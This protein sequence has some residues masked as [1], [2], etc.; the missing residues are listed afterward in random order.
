MVGGERSSERLARERELRPDL[1]DAASLS[2][3]PLPFPL[4]LPLGREMELRGLSD[5]E[6]GM[7]DLQLSVKH[8]YHHTIGEIR[9]T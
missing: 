1:T 3:S 8:T 4:L 7:R 9:P 6:P 2:A 5:L